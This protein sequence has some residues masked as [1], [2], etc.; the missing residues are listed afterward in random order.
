MQLKHAAL[1]LGAVL[2][3]ISAACGPVGPGLGLGPALDPLVG[4]ILLVALVL[5][6]GWLVKS[7]VRSPAGQAIE[8]QFSEAGQAVR[9]RLHAGTDDRSAKRQH[10]GDAAPRAEEI[11]RERYARGEID[12]KQY[13][14]M[15]EDLKNR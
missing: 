8:R 3:L 10:E 12:R 14:E 4:L 1:W 2:V 5:G 11:L 6:G 13:L 7:A 9:D 15:L